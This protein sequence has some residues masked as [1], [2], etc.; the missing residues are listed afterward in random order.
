MDENLK[1]AIENTKNNIF[2]QT[3]ELNLP[4]QE[5]SIDRLKKQSQEL[6]GYLK[7]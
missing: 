5:D 1:K 3:P 7:K 2:P 4:K 6:M